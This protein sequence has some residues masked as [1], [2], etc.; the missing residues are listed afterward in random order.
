MIFLVTV[1]NIRLE[2]PILKKKRRINRRFKGVK[3]TI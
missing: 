1:R 3:K 2:I